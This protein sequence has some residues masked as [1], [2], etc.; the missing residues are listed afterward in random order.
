MEISEVKD[1]LNRGYKINREM[2]HLD[3][4]V[5]NLR[6]RAASVTPQYGGE[7]V[8]GTKDPHKM[9]GYLEAVERYAEIVKERIDAL[10]EVSGEIVRVI[11][12]VRD[13]RERA[14]LVDRYLNFFA[15]ERIAVDMSYS[16]MQVTRIHGRALQSVKAILEEAGKDVIE[17]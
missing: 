13:N 11:Y 15:W 4:S 7:A 10:S 16:Y 1:W 5:A 6:S 14:V 3:M 9:D 8:A 17:C 12:R 2:E